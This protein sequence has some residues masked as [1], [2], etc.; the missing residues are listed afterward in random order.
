MAEA[1]PF[2]H[3]VIGELREQIGA[4]AMRDI[5]RRLT[6]NGGQLIPV[7]VDAGQPIGERCDAAH[8]LK[9]ACAVVGMSR[10]SALCQ[11]IETAWRD[12]LNEQAEKLAADLPARFTADRRQL[13][14]LF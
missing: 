8:S 4:E 14:T 12:G 13:E 10:I 11:A 9:G 6:N 2:D 1:E 3:G 7:I 5:L